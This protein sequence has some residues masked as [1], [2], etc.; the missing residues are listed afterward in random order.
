MWNK[1]MIKSC[2]KR[3]DPGSDEDEVQP[4]KYKIKTEK[5]CEYDEITDRSSINSEHSFKKIIVGD[6]D[7]IEDNDGPDKTENHG[8]EQKGEEK[9]ES[10]HS[11][12]L[13]GGA[14]G[15]VES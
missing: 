14:D 6:L 8:E 7:S 1:R 3:V 10:V 12:S 9:K 2:H 15:K 11:S 4:P 5:L 13:E